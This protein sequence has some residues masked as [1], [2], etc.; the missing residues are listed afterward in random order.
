MTDHRQIEAPLR[1]SLPRES[2]QRSVSRRRAVKCDE[3]ATLRASRNRPTAPRSPARYSASLTMRNCA[4]PEPTMVRIQG[5]FAKV[6]ASER[7]LT[8]MISPN[9]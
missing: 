1:S 6:F 4:T 3:S 8:T 2:C 5:P 9:P 7:A